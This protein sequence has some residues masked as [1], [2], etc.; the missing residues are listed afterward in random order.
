MIQV[1]WVKSTAGGWLNL[2]T[3]NLSNVNTFGVY[4]IWK[5]GQP[6]SCVRVGQGDIKARLIAHKADAA[7]CAHN[8]LLVTWASVSAVQAD[9][10]ERFLADHYGPLVGAAFP[11]ALPIAV[12]LVA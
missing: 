7:I 12:N 10:V 1:N 5:A 2:H 9:G 6:A 3:V 11:N 8:P 4:V